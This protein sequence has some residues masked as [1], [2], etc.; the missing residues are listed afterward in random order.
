M[1]P[2]KSCRRLQQKVLLVLDRHAIT[3]SIEL[4]AAQPS[5]PHPWKRLLLSLARASMGGTR[6]KWLLSVEKR[7]VEDDA[8]AAR[9]NLA[10]AS[11]GSSEGRGGAVSVAEKRGRVGA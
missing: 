5:L 9:Q 3:F 7:E 6:K 11:F 2:D 1:A 4:R 8:L 10:F